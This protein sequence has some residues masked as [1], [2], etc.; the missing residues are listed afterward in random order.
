MPSRRI[1]SRARAEAVPS[2]KRCRV[3]IH[4]TRHGRIEWNIGENGA[5]HIAVAAGSKQLSVRIDDHDDA[6]IGLLQALKGA[7]QAGIRRDS[8]TGKIVHN[9]P[10]LC[11]GPRPA[12]SL[13]QTTRS[14]MTNRFACSI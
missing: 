3:G 14:P 7:T 1:T 2:R 5:A 13:Q 11:L 9:V 12:P 10:G 6:K 4:G 8:R